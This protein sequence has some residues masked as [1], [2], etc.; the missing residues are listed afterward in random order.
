MSRQRRDQPGGIAV[1]AELRHF[2]VFEHEEHGDLH[3]MGLARLLHFGGIIHDRKNTV[4]LRHELAWLE[5]CEVVSLRNFLKRLSNLSLALVRAGLWN[6]RKNR[7]EL[8]SSA[9]YISDEDY[10]LTASVSQEI[11]QCP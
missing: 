4:V 5:L 6:D 2:A 7:V 8:V 11:E 9:A 1:L 10:D 3:H